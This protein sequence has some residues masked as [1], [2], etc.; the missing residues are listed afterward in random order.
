M[1]VDLES[2]TLELKRPHSVRYNFKVRAGRRKH[3]GVIRER[4]V[5]VSRGIL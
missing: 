4:P 3:R 2:D 5:D 1:P